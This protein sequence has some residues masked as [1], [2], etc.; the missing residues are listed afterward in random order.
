M[1]DMIDTDIVLF[2]NRV[3]ALL[4]TASTRSIWTYCVAVILC[5]SVAVLFCSRVIDPPTNHVRTPSDFV[6]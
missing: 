2:Y 6:L 3:M 5:N 1:D 4:M